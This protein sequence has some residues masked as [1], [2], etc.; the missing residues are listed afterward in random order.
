[1]KPS[2]GPSES[3]P[4]WI[5]QTQKAKW[6]ARSCSVTQ[7]GMITAYCSLDL[8]SSW[9]HR[10]TPP[11]P[12]NSFLF[13]VEMRSFYVVQA[14]RE[15]LG[16]SDSP[17]LAFQIAGIILCLAFI[18]ILALGSI[19][20]NVLETG[21]LIAMD[22]QRRVQSHSPLMTEPEL[23]HKEVWRSSRAETKK[24][25]SSLVW[26]SPNAILLADKLPTSSNVEILPIGKPPLLL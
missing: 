17:A 8:L 19:Q 4:G 1:M 15:L 3:R 21:K 18:F 16:S 11:C 5:K 10:H 24:G 6:A 12:A 9:D 7:A 25:G 2:D 26:E 23:L 22:M 13:F 20:R 14:D